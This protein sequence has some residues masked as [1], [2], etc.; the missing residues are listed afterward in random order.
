MQH[1]SKL[2]NNFNGR[3][4]QA[5]KSPTLL[6][7]YFLCIG[8]IIIGILLSGIFPSSANGAVFNGQSYTGATAT[9]YS[10]LTSQQ[11]LRI[12]FY[13][14]ES[15]GAYEPTDTGAISF[16]GGSLSEGELEERGG[17]DYQF[18]GYYQKH[19][20]GDDQNRI[21]KLASQLSNNNL[22]WIATL[23]AENGLWDMYRKHPYKNK[24]GTT[25]WACGLNSAYHAPFIE[26]IEAHAVTEKEILQ[27][28]YDAYTR[29][30]TA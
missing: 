4:G 30:A 2:T 3:P 24:N 8:G 12:K 18:T 19:N 11:F 28:G 13:E 9:G 7:L 1:E 26:K 22:D 20:V 29:R 17:Q 14:S 27:Y 23:E 15:I 6:D 10:S 21:V 25:D 16:G 5:K